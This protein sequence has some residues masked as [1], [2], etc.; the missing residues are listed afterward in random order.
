M[1]EYVLP[2]HANALGNVFGGQIM[3]WSIW[4]G[5]DSAKTRR[6]AA[7]TA[8]VDD[9]MFQNPVKVG[10]KSKPQ[11]SLPRHFAHVDGSRSHRHRGRPV[12]ATG[13]PGVGMR[14]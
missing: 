3:A 13:W 12:D 5:D 14:F 6:S 7:V 11:S 8:F 1:T 9:L 2:Q 10:A 4:C